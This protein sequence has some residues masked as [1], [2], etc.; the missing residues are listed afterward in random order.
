MSICPSDP[1]FSQ[2][3]FLPTTL[4]FTDPT[5]RLHDEFIIYILSSHV[6]QSCR[7]AHTLLDII[8]A[9]ALPNI[10][11]AHAL[12]DIIVSHALL[13]FIVAHALLGIIVTRNPSSDLTS[14]ASPQIKLNNQR[15]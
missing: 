5:C 15:F 8:V 7:K 4:D 14:P 6:F 11:L 13:N 3:D 10:I 2:H 1:E 12:F 9:Y